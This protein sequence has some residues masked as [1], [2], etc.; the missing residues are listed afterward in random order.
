MDSFVIDAQSGNFKQLKNLLKYEEAL[1]R[2][3]V[4]LDNILNA[5]DSRNHS[6]GYLLVLKAKI[7]DNGKNKLTFVDQCSH[8]FST[9]STDQIKLAPEQFTTL[10]KYYAEVLHDVKQPIKGIIPLK[11]AMRALSD[12][13][14]YQVL[15]PIHTDL[16]QVCILSKCYHVA[17]PIIEANITSINPKESAI[18]IKDIL[19][20]FYYSGII[21]TALKKYKK[22]LEAYKFVLT[23]PASALSA[24]VVEAY[25]KFVVVCLIQYGSIQHFPR[26]TPTVVQRNIKSHCK[27]YMDYGFTFPNS[28]ISEVQQKAASSAELFQKDNNWGLIKTSIKSIY[29]RNIKKLTQTFMTL[30]INDIAEKVNLPKAKAEQF[31]LKMIEEGE[32]F[33]TINQKDGMVSFHESLEDFSGSVVLEDLNRNIRNVFDLEKKIR[34]MDESISLSNQYLKK[35][36]NERKNSPQFDE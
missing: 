2:Q 8:F 16:L 15:T 13:K 6:L 35:V 3:F 31:V 7:S 4:A 26:N 24:I 17:L 25:K 19:C 34:T 5:L 29:R 22:A 27:V 33:A 12:N 11:N 9:F 18:G 36:Y 28:S 10:S 23:A 20:F 1:E 32:I 21:F 14:P 30:S